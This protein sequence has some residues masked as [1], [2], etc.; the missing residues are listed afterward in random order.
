M[1]VQATTRPRRGR[2]PGSARPRN[3][4]GKAVN[5]ISPA[6]RKAR[7]SADEAPGCGAAR[8]ETRGAGRF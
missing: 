3:P 7:K 1:S 5:D 6:K 2:A 4:S 8:R